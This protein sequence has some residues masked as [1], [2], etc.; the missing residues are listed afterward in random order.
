MKLIASELVPLKN[1]TELAPAEQLAAL[2]QEN[3][4]E[5]VTDEASAA[6][7]SIATLASA[8][9]AAYDFFT[10]DS[11]LENE[12]PFTFKPSSQP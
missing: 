9:L 11:C 2:P 5:V 7:E 1:H 12:Q 4:P 8:N 6:C 3:E 10:V